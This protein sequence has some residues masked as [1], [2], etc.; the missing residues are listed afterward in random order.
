[1]KRFYSL[2]AL[3]MLAACSISA[4]RITSIGS[5]VTDGNFNTSDHY[6][7]KLVSYKNSGT[8]TTLTEDKYFYAVSGLGG[9]KNRVR[10]STIDTSASTSATNTTNK[11]LTNLCTPSVA[12]DG[13]YAIGMGTNYV[14]S[15]TNG[16]GGFD[17]S[18]SKQNY[19]YKFVSNGDGTYKMQGYR[20]ATAGLYLTYNSSSDQVEVA[21]SADDAMIVKVVKVNTNL[22]EGK[23]YNLTIRGTGSNNYMV[24]DNGICI[25][26]KATKSTATDGIWFFKK[27][28]NSLC[29]W[30]MYNAEVGLDYG[31]TAVTTNN[32]RA[33][34]TSTPTSFLASN[35]KDDFISNGGF[36]LIVSGTATL[37]DVSSALGVWDDNAAP[38][39]GGSSI[40]ATAV[41]DAYALC[42][43]TYTDA[44]HNLSVV[45]HTYQK[46]GETPSIPSIDFFTA[47]TENS[48]LTAVSATES[49]NSYAISGTFS[50]PFTISKDNT[51]AW[52]AMSVRLGEANHDVV[53][54]GS[55]IET[56]VNYGNV[57]TT[58]SRFNDGLYSFIQ[59]GNSE[60]FKIKT[61]SGK[62]LQFIKTTGTVD[63][64][65]NVYNK[66]DLTTTTNENEASEF[67]IAH[68]KR[69]GAAT[70][71]FII[72]PI[73]SH[74]S[75]SNY[76]IGD[77]NSNK[78]TVWSGDNN[79]FTDNGSRFAVKAVETAD[80][81]AIGATVKANELT[82]AAPSTYVGGY[83]ATAIAAFKTASY[84]TLADLEAK[85]T[86]F[87][88]DD[89][90]L[91]QPEEN[92][93]Y[94][95]RFTRYGD[96][97][98]AYAAFKNAVADK[99][100]NVNAG[101]GNTPSERLIGLST[102]V[103]TS[104]LVRFVK[105]GDYYNIQDVNSG[106]YYGSNGE[107]GKIYAVKEADHAGNY[108]LYNMGSAPTIGLKENKSTD[109]S[110][111]LLFCCG[112]DIAGATSTYDYLQLH[113]P[114]TNNSTDESAA[115][116]PGCKMLIQ[117]V[118]TSPLTISEAQ[119]ASL[120]LPYSVTLPEGL[121]ANKVTAVTD[122][123]KELS[124][125]SIGSTIAAGEPVIV[126]G[127]AGSYTLTVNADNGTKSN[128]NL[129]TGASVKRTGITDT[130][131]ALGYKAIGDATEKT[132]GFYK[133]STTNMPAN[134]AY[135]LKNNIPT[136]AQAAMMFSFNFGGNTTGIN[137]ATATDNDADSNVYYDL[138]G[139]RMLYPA[140]GIYIKGNGKKV[141]IK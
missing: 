103:T 29:R 11:F 18:S 27:D 109:A 73:Y 35:G 6:V 116:E 119:Y 1:M 127:T 101:S 118:T 82:A 138:N 81:M 38:T 31:V 132:V 76:V 59:S 84:S 87:S 141:F 25:N 49:Q 137:N 32:S 66:R 60:N 58:Y 102:S 2:F 9:G 51:E 110:K 50:Y 77:H 90:H 124:L 96:S 70:T 97:S 12:T 37:N 71:D 52:Y 129:L 88:T 19:G 63:N 69:S 42:T 16:K 15:F 89:S 28:P 74:L 5:E 23:M 120:C 7:I 78:L 112:D 111:Q 53:V 48:S 79:A 93:L 86:A 85:A 100:G 64:I 57:A 72:V 95:L 94:T 123:N 125:E 44:T 139:R 65:R 56:G 136:S 13:V 83:S 4:Q 134:K 117:E 41:A 43:F 92:K 20:G 91:Q 46:V 8:T 45:R 68:S 40:I 22:E 140:H 67:M 47:T 54:N 39:D 21:S 30:Y 61:R 55:S 115:Y 113:G 121:T 114:R 130:Y 3:F 106:F 62:Y 34:F 135:L 75:T 99:D 26:T 17:V 133:V 33:M 10:L 24:F 108:S 104:A 105:N 128:N 122:D 98:P 131:Y 14:T 80:I 36:S 126:Q 107:D